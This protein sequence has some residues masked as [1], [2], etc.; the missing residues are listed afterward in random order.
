MVPT[1]PL[2]PVNAD[3][4]EKAKTDGHSAGS[5]E[6]SGKYLVRPGGNTVIGRFYILMQGMLQGKN[7]MTL[8]T[9]FFVHLL[10]ATWSVQ[11]ITVKTWFELQ[12]RQ[13]ARGKN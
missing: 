5:S 1:V 3:R 6:D 8:K 7:V 10:F 4:Q 13:A 9:T 11:S 12:T 2:C